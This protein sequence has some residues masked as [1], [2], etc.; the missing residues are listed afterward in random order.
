MDEGVVHATLPGSTSP[1]CGR[2][3][4][5]FGDDKIIDI[6]RFDEVSERE[7]KCWECESIV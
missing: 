4:R 6:D 1:V 3:L 5:M 2:A 7:N